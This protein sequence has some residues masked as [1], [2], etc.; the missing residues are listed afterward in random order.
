MH[1]GLLWKKQL[2]QNGLRVLSYSKPS[3]LTAQLAVAIEYGANDDLEDQAGAAHFLEHLVPGGSKKRI[4]ASREFERL[5]GLSDFFT[6][7]EYTMSIVDVVPNK[8]VEAS[9][10]MFPLLFEG[11]FEEEQFNV[12]RK[13]IFHELA[14]VA[15]DPHE[16]V[17]EMLRQCLFKGHP[18]RRSV[19]GSKKT[20]RNLSLPQLTEIYSRRYSPQNAILVLSGNFSESDFSSVCRNFERE[21]KSEAQKRELRQPEIEPPK[22]IALKK[23]AGLALTYL[24]LGARTTNSSNPDVAALDVLNVV[25]GIGA[26]S[27]LFIELRE[28]L[29]LTYSIG[30]SQTDGLDFGYLGIDCALKQKHVEEAERL[31]LKQLSKLRDEKVPEAELTKGKD[32]ILGD[33]F[34]GVDS[35]ETCPE[36]L[37]IMEIQFGSENGLV[38]YVNR[39]KAVTAEDVQDVS[40]KYLQENQFATAVLAPKT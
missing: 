37:A 27:R 13:I 39:V 6:N 32:M 21:N 33:V 11:G 15:D 17:N 29:A 20:V 12:E 16:R 36:I 23:K 8:L 14:E 3:S 26:S 19:G 1:S 25:L 9:Q 10:N 38:D 40:N 2:L 30:S 31:I 18:V 34:R 7:P 24:S 35:G 5:G 4:E 22:R 28:K